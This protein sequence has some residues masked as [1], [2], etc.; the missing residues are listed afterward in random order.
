MTISAAPNRRAQ[1]IFSN[2][3]LA[4]SIS[5]LIST[6]LATISGNVVSQVLSQTELVD[7]K[8]K[9]KS[10][11]V[12]I[13]HEP[14]GYVSIKDDT[15]KPGFLRFLSLASFYEYRLPRA[16]LKVSQ[17]KE[18]LTLKEGEELQFRAGLRK[19]PKGWDP[20]LSDRNVFIDEP[21]RDKTVDRLFKRSHVKINIA[22][23]V[24]F[25]SV[26]ALLFLN[27]RITKRDANAKRPTLGGVCCYRPRIWMSKVVSSPVGSF[28]WRH[29]EV[30]G[31]LVLTVFIVLLAVAAIM[32]AA[33]IV[34]LLQND[35]FCGKRCASS[36]LDALAI[37]EVDACIESCVLGKG[38]N[39]AVLASCLW[40]LVVL[41]VVGIAAI[42]L[43]EAK[44]PKLALALSSRTWW[45]TVCLPL[46]IRSE[47]LFPSLSLPLSHDR[48][49][50]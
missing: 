2:L 38:G 30:V 12:A 34:M 45:N 13:V 28:L 49:K 46:A 16:I 32:P 9:K 31:L 26:V 14:Y 17:H 33:A 50:Q 47:D 48:H 1:R 22:L 18:V 36:S 3:V 11:Q 23:V 25:L 41:M 15:G 10:N 20:S 42:S 39:F 19:R 21:Y 43:I 37:L 44:L 35:V 7:G 27:G 5:A 6:L 4:L 40:F 24:G 8:A 29:S